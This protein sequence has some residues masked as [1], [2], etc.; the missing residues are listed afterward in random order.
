MQSTS[1][2]VVSV[3]PAAGAELIGHAVVTASLFGTVYGSAGTVVPALG[4][5]VPPCAPAVLGTSE[6]VA[7]ITAR[8][9]SS[10]L[11]FF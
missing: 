7:Q 11:R 2:D 6:T 9:N 8:L 10:A 3:N 4:T 1:V 5:L